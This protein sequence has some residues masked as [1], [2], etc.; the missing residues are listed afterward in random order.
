MQRYNIFLYYNTFLNFFSLIIQKL[1]FVYHI[2]ENEQNKDKIGINTH[3]RARSSISAGLQS[4]PTGTQSE[5]I[6]IIVQNRISPKRDKFLYIS[7]RASTGFRKSTQKSTKTEKIA[8]GAFFRGANF[9]KVKYIGGSPRCNS[10]HTLGR[11][12]KLYI[13]FLK[14]FWVLYFSEK[15]FF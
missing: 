15:K 8:E 9:Q 3:I 5:N 2:S 10:R 14:F 7:G 11:K 13:F 4:I 1:C 6:Q 12:K